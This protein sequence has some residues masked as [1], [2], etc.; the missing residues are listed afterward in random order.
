MLWEATRANSK[1]G[2]GKTH[3]ENVKSIL[4]E[5]AED[6]DAGPPSST[7]VVVSS[8]SISI[9]SS[10]PTALVSSTTGVTSDST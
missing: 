8:T 3:Y 10:G 9:S 2:E 7:S 5:V 4:C 6:C 1:I